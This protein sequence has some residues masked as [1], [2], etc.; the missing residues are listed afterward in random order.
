[1]NIWLQYAILGAASIVAHE[2]GHA[3]AARAVGIRVAGVQIGTG[4]RV[5]RI[6]RVDVRAWP[7][8]IGIRIPDAVLA[9]APFGAR[10]VVHAAGPLINLVLAGLFAISN[11]HSLGAAINLALAGG[12]LL[13]LP[14]L[15]GGWIV[16]AV[17][18][19]I[20]GQPFAAERRFHARYR[21]L[22]FVLGFAI[23]L[24][25]GLSV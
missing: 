9:R 7:I 2:F 14:A 25:V 10:I 18:A 13:P 17:A 5:A 22:S 16:T 3:A 8:A 20:A 15:D 19:R 1:M 11:P 6:R 21:R 4:W 24:V 23:P 12:N